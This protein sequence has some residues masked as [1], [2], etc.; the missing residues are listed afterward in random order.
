MATGGH[1]ALALESNFYRIIQALHG[2]GCIGQLPLGLAKCCK[3]W[4]GRVLH[5]QT[6]HNAG[7][8]HVMP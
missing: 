4:Q 6:L 7:F 8:T 3:S 2:V 1:C 5:A